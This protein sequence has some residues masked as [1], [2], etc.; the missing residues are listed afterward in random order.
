MFS[1]AKQ[2]L[3]RA[4]RRGLR[5]AVAALAM[6]ACWC[7]GPVSALATP[8]VV[9]RANL[10]PGVSYRRIDDPTIPIHTYL[11]AFSPGYPAT[12]DGVL[13]AGKIGG[14]ERT[15]AMAKAAGAL[16]AING[17]LNSSP[18]RPTHQY[19]L[20]GRMMQTGKRVGVSFGFRQ[21]ETGGMVG[22]H[23]IRISAVDES[24]GASVQVKS[25]NEQ[26][27]ATDQVVGYTPYGG[28]EEKPATNQCSA[29]LTLPSGMRWN[30]DQNG[31]HRMYTVDA[32][33]CSSSTAM[34]VTAGS[35]VLTAKTSGLGATYIKS[36]TV[37]RRVRVAW[38]ADGPGVL[39]IVSGNAM[40]LVDGRVVYRSSCSMNICRRNPR[41]AIGIT[42]NGRVMMLVVDGRTSV[43]AGFTLHRLGHWMRHLGVVNAVNLDGGGSSTMWLAGRGVVNHPTDS[44]GERPVS[45]AVVILP[46][47]D[48][49]EV[50]PRAVVQP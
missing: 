14:Y 48:P 21:D 34:G 38:R 11:L 6:V 29:R 46:G 41:T 28:T 47:A 13:S 22:R 5:R 26:S 49:N 25:W 16:A 45:N 42:R 8:T 33:A 3:A 2:L 4:N 10:A 40:I 23:P 20:D 32:V 24:T 1:S 18:G 17:D 27:P 9:A 31:V 15:S 43:S 7:I 44:T 50:V 39:D 30:R 12:L 19:V 35:V 37:G 36:L